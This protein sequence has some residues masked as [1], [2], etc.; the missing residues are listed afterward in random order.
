MNKNVIVCDVCNKE[1]SQLMCNQNSPLDWFLI[2]K[3]MAVVGDA[4]NRTET[5]TWNICSKS[6]LNTFSY[7]D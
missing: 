1:S 3:T 4:F 6:C 2:Y 7:N 5:K